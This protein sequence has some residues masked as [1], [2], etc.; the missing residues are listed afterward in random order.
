M[1]RLRSRSS[2]SLVLW[3]TTI[4]ALVTAAAACGGATNGTLLAIDAKTGQELWRVRPPGGAV[5]RATTA[6]GLVFVVTSNNCNSLQGTLVAYDAA[7][8]RERWRA[9]SVRGCFSSVSARRGLVV[10][11]GEKNVQG[12]DDRD[13]SS[14]WSAELTGGRDVTLI[15]GDIWLS[16]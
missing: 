2:V 8:G 3:L 4:A 16:S 6:D 14:R 7:L 1:D 10:A 11:L 12:L 15:D 13:G 9:P 5:G